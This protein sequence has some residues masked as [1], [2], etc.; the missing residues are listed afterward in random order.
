MGNGKRKKTQKRQAKVQT[1]TQTHKRTHKT[2][3]IECTRHSFWGGGGQKLVRKASIRHVSCNTIGQ[4]SFAFLPWPFR[5][6]VAPFPP[7]CC[8]VC[9]GLLIVWQTTRLTWCSTMCTAH[10]VD[11]PASCI[12]RPTLM[13]QMY[14]YILTSFGS[15]LIGYYPQFCYA[16]VVLPYSARA[17][18]VNI[19]AAACN[20]NVSTAVLVAAQINSSCSKQPSEQ[21]TTP[22][23]LLRP[24]G[25]FLPKLGEEFPPSAPQAFSQ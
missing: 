20:T 21:L 15:D 5:P 18:L 16:L 24:P 22:T 1:N 10:P 4:V 2:T 14:K 11:Y 19:V 23:F 6:S 9:A 3:K 13:H 25:A 8:S 17:S 12:L 7:H